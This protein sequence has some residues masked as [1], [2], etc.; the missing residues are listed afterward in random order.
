MKPEVY[1]KY[2]IKN[3]HPGLLDEAFQ[4]IHFECAPA[5]TARLFKLLHY[6]EKSRSMKKI[7]GIKAKLIELP[8]GR[9]SEAF[10]I[11]YQT[12]CRRLHMGYNIKVLSVSH[13]DI[14]CLDKKVE[15]VVILNESPHE[16]LPMPK[17]YSTQRQEYLDLVSPSDGKEVVHAVIRRAARQI[18]QADAIV[19]HHVEHLRLLHNTETNSAM[20]WFNYWTNERKY[21]SSTVIKLLKSFEMNSALSAHH[22]SWHSA[23]LT[24][25]SEFDT[26]NEAY[27]DTMKLEE[28]DL[29]GEDGSAATSNANVMVDL[30]TEAMKD[31]HIALGDTGN[32]SMGSA[33]TGPSCRSNFFSSTGNSMARSVNAARLAKDHKDRAL[34]NA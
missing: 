31:L 2:G 15:I 25:T 30:S 7:F 18:G 17:K 8:E 12:Q 3:N 28:Y 20:F 21:T 22:S 24:V 16:G 5:D 26:A 13:N 4:M 29:D 33:K 10:W 14:I 32:A 9:M 27:I 23:T 6:M 19:S 34:E 11:K 1:S